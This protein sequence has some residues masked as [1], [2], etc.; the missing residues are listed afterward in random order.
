EWEPEEVNALNQLGY[1]AASAGSLDTAL[2]ALR[3]Y[4]A[5]RPAEANP[6]DSQG[7]VNLLAGGLRQAGSPSLQAAK[8]D[9][10]FAGGGDLW[11]AAVARLMS[12]DVAGASQLAQ[13]YI[14]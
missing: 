5:L 12:G 2:D 7:D 3:R 14:Q 8:K 4:Q 11:K 6:L 9:P 1:A 13:Q 10:N